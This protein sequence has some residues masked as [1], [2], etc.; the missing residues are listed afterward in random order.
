MGQTDPRKEIILAYF[1]DQEYA[2]R[3]EYKQRKEKLT[4]YLQ[5]LENVP[6][7]GIAFEPVSTR[8]EYLAEIYKNHGYSPKYLEDLRL[9]GIKQRDPK[10]EALILE[11]IN[12]Y[13]IEE[14]YR[15]LRFLE[16]LPPREM[17]N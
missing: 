17:K 1:H 6:A 14:K 7:K 13:E 10:L 11:Q 8:A 2:K 4:N 16:E 5:D 3:E 12:N 9:V 15:R